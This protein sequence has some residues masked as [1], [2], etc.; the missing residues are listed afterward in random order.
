MKSKGAI[1]LPLGASISYYKNLILERGRENENCKI[2]LL[3][4]QINEHMNFP[5]LFMLYKEGQK[6][7]QA[8]HLDAYK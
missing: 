5:G 2:Y 3:K 6:L 1:F 4:K 8:N 7:A